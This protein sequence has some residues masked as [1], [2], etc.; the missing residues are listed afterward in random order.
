MERAKA[1]AGWLLLAPA[2]VHSLIFIALPAVTVVVLSLTDA[3]VIGG[4]SFVGLSNYAELLDDPLFHKAVQHTILYTI[5]VVPVAMAIAILVALGLNQNIRGRAVFRTVFYIPVVTS[6]VAVASV[7]LWIYNP[8]SG[9]GNEFLSFLGI[10]PSGWLTDPDAA[11][12][13]L[14]AIGIWQGLGAKMVLYLAALQNVSPELVEAAK[15]DGANRWQIFWNVTWPALAPAH[16]FV[17][18]TSIA[19]SFQVFDLVFVTTNGGPAN[20]TNV[21]AFDI[22]TNAFQRLETGYAAAETVVMLMIV[23]VFIFLGRLTQRDRKEV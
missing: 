7:W 12:P 3:Q 8:S 22:F 20:A 17:M 1:R 11:L 16:F 10:S 4:G 21:L 19:S 6:T 14:M 2:F 5:A 23:G 15:L 9:L 18:V 13:A